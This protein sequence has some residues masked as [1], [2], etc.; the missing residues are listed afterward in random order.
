MSI[1]V[2]PDV[3]IKKGKKNV[4]MLYTHY[5][6]LTISASKYCSLSSL[7]TLIFTLLN[8]ILYDQH[9]INTKINNVKRL[10]TQA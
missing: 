4:L 9:Q 8:G 2:F 1:F 5:K 3:G 6:Y 10:R 7:M